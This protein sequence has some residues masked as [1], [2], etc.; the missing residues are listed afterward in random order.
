[1]TTVFQEMARLLRGGESIVTATIIRK[2]GSAPRSGG[3]RMLVRADGSILGSIGGGRL[4]AETLQLA[5]EAFRTRRAVLQSF[6]LGGADAAGSAM[7]CGGRGE[8][9]LDYV[10]ARV[11]ANA[12][13]FAEAAEI[14]ARGGTA[15]LLTTF[16]D[17]GQGAGHAGQHG[18]VRPDGSTIGALEVDP[19]LLA[20][21]VSEGGGRSI[22]VEAL[23][24][25]RIVVEPLRDG[26]R[27][28]VF[29]AGHCAQKL[30][31]LA[32]SVDFRTVV[33]DDREEFANRTCFP[34]PTELVRLGAFDRLPELGIDE[35]SYVVIMTRGHL[36]DLVVLEQCLGTRAGYIGMIGSPRKRNKIYD[37]LLQRGFARA[38]LDRVHSPIGI[39]IE[40]ETPEEIAVSIVGELIR[41][42]AEREGR[43]ARRRQA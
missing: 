17:P 26:G 27:V 35:N 31:P 43:G 12:S 11:A 24:D 30:A 42:R 14:L 32:E 3:S 5:A 41:A 38:D 15:W 21:L 6:D 7:I 20:R 37:V 9:L 25:R 2:T 28:L 19:A 13:L 18:L 22:R 8:I 4:E 36:H 29:G 1:M 40:A 16:R 34:E 39:E 33:L 23:A 10:D